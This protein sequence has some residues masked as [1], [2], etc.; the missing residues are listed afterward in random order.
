M[1]TNVNVNVSVTRL[2]SAAVL[3]ERWAPGRCVKLHVLMKSDN[4]GENQDC[5]GKGVCFSK[6]NMVSTT[7]Q[8]Q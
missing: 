7:N 6:E 5:S 2:L 4:C 8:A 3:S 1:L